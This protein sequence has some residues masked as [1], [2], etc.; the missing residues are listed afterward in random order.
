MTATL[1]PPSCSPWHTRP[2]RIDRIRAE[3]PGVRT[4]TLMLDRLP[5]R[6]AFRFAPGQ[7]TMLLLPGIGEC[8][9][10]I[11]AGD[12]PGITH[13]VRAVGNVTEA[14]GRLDVGAPVLVRGPFG[15]PWPLAALRDR[16]LVLVGGGLGLASL[17]AAIHHCLACRGDYGRIDVLHGAKSPA[18]LL[19]AAEQRRWR[20]HGIDVACIVDHGAAAWP[21]PVGIVTDLFA[22]LDIAPA[23]TS[24]LCCGP[25]PMLRAVAQ[26]AVARGIAA[27]AVFVAVERMMACGAGLCGLCQLGPLF[28]CRDGPV[29]AYDRIARWLAVPHL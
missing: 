1:P 6:R 3:A 28:V 13:T 11:T 19:F 5:D 27:E 8:A 10:S 16:D 12:A 2:A 4:Y 26:A 22:K 24:V 17:H 9:L 14:L 18:D 23:T 21:G 25:E 7:F 15:R 20:E 29:F